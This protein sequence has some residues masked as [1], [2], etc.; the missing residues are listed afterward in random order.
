MARSNETDERIDLS[1][2]LWELRCGIARY[3]DADANKASFGRMLTDPGYRAQI[4]DAVRISEKAELRRLA[5]QAYRLNTG[6]VA[7][8]PVSWEAAGRTELDIQELTEGSGRK[9]RKA[10]PLSHAQVAGAASAILLFGIAGGVLSYLLSDPLMAK[11]GEE[12]TVSGEITES[13][14]WSNDHTYV[15][16]DMVHVTDGATLTIERGTRVLG[17]P[18][19]ALI[20]TRA[21]DLQAQGTQT[22]PVVFTSAQPAGER[23]RGDWGGVVLLGEAPVNTADPHIEG[24]PLDDDRG[25][26][27]GDDPDSSCGVMKYARVEFAGHEVAANVELN[28]LTLGGCGRATIVR[29][30]QIHM[31]LDD[32]IEMF[33]GTVNLERLVVTR[34]A[35]DSMDWDLGWRGNVQFAVLQQEGQVG[36]HAIEADNNGDDHDA[37]PRSRPTLS[38]VTF[39][40]SR[41]TGASQRAILLREGT[42]IDL[43]NAII[44]G[45]PA[46]MLDVRNEATASLADDGH[47]RMAGLIAHD[48][49]RTN[50]TWAAAES[51][52]GD[53]DG[54]FDEAEFL[55]SSTK[56]RLGTNPGLPDAAFDLQQ[57]R[58][59]PHMGSPALARSVAI[60]DGEF[61][62]AGAHFVGAFEPG[63]RQTWVDGWTAY[64][65]S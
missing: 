63:T 62:D 22:Q 52:E 30:V 57:P 7:E 56:V 27:G 17:E 44:T 43:R 65:T 29:N 60:P 21:G 54:G 38:N 45:F 37:Q 32:G 18:G 25:D 31:G 61:W 59:V 55:R 64:P 36:D 15:L 6:R 13:T 50:Q 3:G 41:E 58:F 24:I 20:V 11:F 47:L 46:E 16:E 5:E 49:G 12:R 26:F 23:A 28:G 1:Q 4:I 33:G 34:A 51:S 35:D 2:A 39:V 10:A 48:I 14:T 40:G 53:D 19:S 42:G 8:T 9:D